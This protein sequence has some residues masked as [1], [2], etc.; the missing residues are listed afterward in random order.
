MTTDEMVEWA[1]TNGFSQRDIYRMA[2][3]RQKYKSGF[4]T[5]DDIPQIRKQLGLPP[6]KE[7]AVIAWLEK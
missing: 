1:K 5:K 4:I 3:L 7:N 6:E 2:R